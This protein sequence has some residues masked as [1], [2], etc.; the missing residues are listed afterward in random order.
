MFTFLLAT[1]LVVSLVLS[2]LNH[3]ETLKKPKLA[4]AQ[5]YQPH[6]AITEYLVSEK[7]DGVRAYWDGTRFLTRSGNLINPPN[8]FIRDLPNLPLDGE[9]W[10]ARGHF[11][12]VSGIIRRDKPVDEDWLNIKYMVFDLPGYPG[13]FEQRYK[14]LQDLIQPLTLDW[15]QVVQ[16]YPINGKSDLDEHLKRTVAQG[17]E[18]LML[19][20]ANAVYQPGRHDNL[21]K[22]KPAFDDEAKV[23]AHIPGKGKYTNMLGALLVELKDGRQMK[24]G[25]GFTDA[26]RR[27]PPQAGEWITFEYSGLTSTGLPRFARFVRVYEEM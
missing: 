13:G 22:M 9:L 11:S 24:I 8:W 16:Q 2:P 15:L 5:N 17:G 26:E 27:K 14:A 1:V 12:G 18:G 25:T 19:Q 10:I 23:L 3:A 4:L 20:K 21:L 7:L 6:H